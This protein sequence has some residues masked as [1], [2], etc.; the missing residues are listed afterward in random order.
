[1]KGNTMRKV[2]ANN[3][4]HDFV[5]LGF[6]YKGNWYA[7]FST[8]AEMLKESKYGKTSKSHGNKSCLRFR[9]SSA[10]KEYIIN[11]KRFITWNNCD[12]IAEAK[13]KEN[14]G[15]A[16]ERIM[17]QVLKA[18]PCKKCVWYKG[19]DFEY[20]DYI[21]QVKFENGTICTAEQCRKVR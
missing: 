12:I 2:Y 14:R 4:A 15:E 19:G 7:T 10:W 1:M 17:C 18:N 11:T 20:N 8:T 13:D 9:P 16:F 5:L 21:Y 3:N 6:N